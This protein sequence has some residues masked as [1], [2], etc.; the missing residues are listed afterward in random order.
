[1]VL[2]KTLASEKKELRD[3]PHMGGLPIIGH[4]KKMY[5]LTEGLIRRGYSDNNIRAVLGENF[6][7]ALGDIWVS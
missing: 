7:R 6:R 1:M 2:A 3:I 5:D 4:P